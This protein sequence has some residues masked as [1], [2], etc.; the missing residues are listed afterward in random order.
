MYLGGQSA[1]CVTQPGGTCCVAGRDGSGRR[2][3]ERDREEEM[4]RQESFQAEMKFWGEVLLLLNDSSLL[5]S[6]E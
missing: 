4:Q 2:E 5:A 3:R 6:K 1:E